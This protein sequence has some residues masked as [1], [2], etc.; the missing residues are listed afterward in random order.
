MEFWV[1]FMAGAYGSMQE[2]VTTWRFDITLVYFFSS[3]LYLGGLAYHL[4]FAKNL[5]E[6]KMAFLMGLIGS[7]I[8]LSSVVFQTLH[9]GDLEVAGITNVF[10]LLHGDYA[11]IVFYGASFMGFGM[12]TWYFN[13]Y[14]RQKNKFIALI[15]FIS[16]M[17]GVLMTRI[18]FYG[19]INT[20]IMH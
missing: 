1:F 7:G 11:K 19:L 14:L 9:L 15:A 8:L 16:A 2:T 12:I 6:E 4:F 18:I 3:G 13:G 17:I 5:H 20:H 10:N